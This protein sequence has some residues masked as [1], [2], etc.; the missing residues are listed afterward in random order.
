M[1]RVTARTAH[2]IPDRAPLQLTVGDEVQA[3]VHDSEWP[4]FVFVTA[5]HGTGW[6]PARHLSQSSGPVVAQTAYDTTELATRVGEVLDVL[7]ED[8]ISGWLWCRSSSGRQGW[9]PV[10]TVEDDT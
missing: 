5:A 9:V 4:E 1:K 3:G 8:V 2:E 10:R 7:T 6:V